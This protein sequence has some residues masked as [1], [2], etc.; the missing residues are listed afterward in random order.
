MV[1][2]LVISLAQESKGSHDFFTDRHLLAPSI[3]PCLKLLHSMLFL[4]LISSFTNFISS[5]L[6]RHSVYVP[7]C[8]IV[9]FLQMSSYSNRQEALD[10]EI[11]SASTSLAEGE[12]SGHIV[13][14]FCGPKVSFCHSNT[15]ELTSYHWNRHCASE[16][17][18]NLQFQI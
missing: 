14:D 1:F 12:Y 15:G 17:W 10:E 18:Y 9:R 7:R 16:T 8:Y 13:C 2:W 11:L 6:T 4:L 5:K 3:P